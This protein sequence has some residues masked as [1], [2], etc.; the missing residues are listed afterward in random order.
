MYFHRRFITGLILFLTATGSAYSL[1]RVVLTEIMY[2][3][4]SEKLSEEFIEIYNAGPDPINIENWRISGEVD[5]TFPELQLEPGAYHVIAADPEQLQSIQPELN[6]LLGPWK[7]KLGNNG[8]MI[9]LQNDQ[10]E[11]VDSVRY[12]SQGEWARRAQGTVDRGFKGWIWTASHDGQGSSLE[13]RN[14]KLPN[15]YGANWIG[16]RTLGGSPGNPN[17]QETN[18]LA[19]MILDVS[20]SPAVPRSFE[21]VRIRCCL[22]DEDPGSLSVNLFFRTNDLS[23]FQSLA[24]HLDVDQPAS[25]TPGIGYFTTMPAL[26]SS[27]IVEFYIEAKDSEGNLRTSPLPVIPSGDQETNYL[28]QVDDEPY[29]GSMPGYRFIMTH[30]EEADLKAIGNLSWFE[31]SN[32]RMNAT[33]IYQEAGK[34]VIRYHVGIRLRGGT[35]RTHHPKNRRIQIPNDRPL[36]GRRAIVLNALRPHSQIIGSAIF[37][38]AGLA[39]QR[40]RPSHVIENNRRP[41]L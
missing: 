1:P 20:H 11:R 9:R 21:T 12:A 29:F 3:P 14:P 31:S 24:M 7:G 17:S 19:P 34:T 2:R 6:A 15:E 18:N 23:D 10:N 33:L 28:Y 39:V 37:R 8:G 22:I 26:P 32:A 13:L 41:A 30:K 16:S 36:N 38:S 4:R 27:S 35:S 40:A 5:F 25:E